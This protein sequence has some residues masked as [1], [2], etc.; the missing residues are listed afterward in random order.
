MF[1]RKVLPIV[2]PGFRPD[3]RTIEDI[4]DH[5]TEFALGG[6][7]RLAAQRESHARPA[8]RRRAGT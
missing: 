1:V 7:E 6:I 2:D 8:A 5:I 4:A 3:A